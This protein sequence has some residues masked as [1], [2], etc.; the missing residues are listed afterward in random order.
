MVKDI[1]KSTMALFSPGPD[2]IEIGVG[3]LAVG[4]LSCRLIAPALGSCVALAL[5][6]PVGKQGGMAH[7]MLPAPAQGIEPASPGRFATYAV[8]ELVRQLEHRGSKRRRLLA[9]IAGGA[10]MFRGEAAIAN[11][12]RRNIAEVKRQLSLM[13]IPLVAEDTGEGHARTVELLVDSGVVLVRSYQF[14]VRRL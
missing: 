3:E 14:G 1:D 4:D 2:L 13:S 8:A 7:I 6:D 5:W 12:G 9:K 11:I 10:A